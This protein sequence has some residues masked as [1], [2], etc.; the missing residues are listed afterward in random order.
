LKCY[1]QD[2]VEQ[3]EVDNMRG[4]QLRINFDIIFPRLPC[5]VVSVDALDSSG[6]RHFDLIHNVFK[7][8]L[9]A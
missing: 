8:R 5:A 1:S 3:M 4:N 7:K 6:G 9:D 2:K